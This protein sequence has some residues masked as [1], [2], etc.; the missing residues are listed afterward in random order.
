[1]AEPSDFRIK[2]DIMGRL[3]KIPGI[4]SMSPQIF[5]AT[6]NIPELSPDPVNLYGIDPETDFTI[7]PWLQKP[8]DKPLGPGEVIIGSAVA[9]NPGTPL[10]IRD[11]K[12]T[13]AGKLDLTRSS[14][15]HA[16]ILRLE[17]AYNLANV[18]GVL[19]P[20][21]PKIIAGDVSAIL[22]RDVPDEKLKVVGDRI[23]RAFYLSPESRTVRVIN[24]HF[25]LEPVNEDI[26]G[27]PDLLNLISVFVVI[28]AL[29]LIA[30]ISAMVA[31][32]RQREI[33]LLK[34]MGAKR[35][36]IFL[37]VFTESLLL[38]AF[39]GIAGITISVFALYLMD[40]QGSL[41]SAHQVSFFIPTVIEIGAMAGLALLIVIFIG[42]IS[43]LWPAYR[44]SLM[45]PYEAIRSEG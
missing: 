8:L 39:G 10:S 6:L 3:K 12:Y 2:G 34:A 5:I 43:S 16:V 11:Q 42:S 45:N 28:V 26:Q 40:T 25:S 21:S 17:D 20:S 4:V 33:G 31:H 29:P 27:I 44:G 19:P 24:R 14:V 9:G 1:M 37:L 7:K 22:I 36:V 41:N 32:E 15:D 30:L 38:S 23:T 18:K 13:I 35:N